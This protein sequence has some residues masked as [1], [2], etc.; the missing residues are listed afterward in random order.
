MILKRNVLNGLLEWIEHRLA[1][2]FNVLYSKGAVP[3]GL[4]RGS[5]TTSPRQTV[6][7]NQEYTV[8]NTIFHSSLCVPHR[9]LE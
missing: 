4:E 7:L 3:D 8:W 5:A 6:P 2:R 9:I 1:H